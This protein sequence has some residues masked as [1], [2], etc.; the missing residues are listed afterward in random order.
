MKANENQ[1]IRSSMKDLFQNIHEYNTKDDAEFWWFHF[2]QIHVTRKVY[3]YHK[4][5][6]KNRWTIS[7]YRDFI[8]IKVNLETLLV[9]KREY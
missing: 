9:W 2:W 3:K 1:W 8:S 7:R 4:Y 6:H 5:S